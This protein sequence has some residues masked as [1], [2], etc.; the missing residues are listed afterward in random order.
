MAL[1]DPAD[2]DRMLDVSQIDTKNITGNKVPFTFNCSLTANKTYT[3]KAY[4]WTEDDKPLPTS[5]SV[6]L[7]K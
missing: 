7:T 5:Y 2:G 6:T 4:I 1:Y 3:V